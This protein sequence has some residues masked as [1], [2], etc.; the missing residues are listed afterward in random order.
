MVNFEISDA[1]EG[2]V[3][4]GPDEGFKEEAS[5]E[6]SPAH[7][8]T[9][10]I[11]L[12]SRR[13]EIVNGLFVDI[14]VPRWNDPEIFVRYRPISAIKLNSAI[15]R[16]RKQKTEDWSILANA[17]MLVE[18]C[19]GVYCILHGNMDNKYSLR[20]A[21]ASGDFTKFDPDLSAALG[22]PAE[23]AVDVCRSLYLT[24]G[25][26]IDA[27]NR[28]FKWSGIANEEADETF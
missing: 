20:I 21:D 23:R 10:L 22:I 1:D 19:L 8:E 18:A 5:F 14:Q 13:E 17:D 16:R 15:E 26:L 3:S 11:S 9:P 4:T 2:A 24:E 6:A 25:D 28:L 7:T 12:K 27:A